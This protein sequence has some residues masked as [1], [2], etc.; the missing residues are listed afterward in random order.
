MLAVTQGTGG[1]RMH[2]LTRAYR[3]LGRILSSRRR[4]VHNVENASVVWN[5]WSSCWVRWVAAMVT[6][7]CWTVDDV[8]LSSLV[9][10]IVERRL[11]RQR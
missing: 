6:M 1:V 11:R 5:G 9:A 7:E 2:V 10:M 3:L 8:G 4:E